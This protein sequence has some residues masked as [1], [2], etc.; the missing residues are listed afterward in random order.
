MKRISCIRGGENDY[1]QLGRQTENNYD[2]GPKEINY[3]TNSK[4]KIKQ[5]C[6][7]NRTIMVLLD[8][9]KVSLWGNNEI[10]LTGKL[11]L[12]KKITKILNRK[13]I[14][15]PKELKSLNEIEFIH[16]NRESCFAI[17]KNYNVFSWGENKYSEQIFSKFSNRKFHPEPVFSDILSKLRIIAINSDSYGI[18]LLSSDG[19]LY[20]CGKQI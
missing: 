8:N 15:K 5:I 7:C 1:G 6:S 9:G 17:D 10:G 4:S 19:K 13:I 12:R 2:H 20:I 18:Y 14:T 16:I 3:F 11:R